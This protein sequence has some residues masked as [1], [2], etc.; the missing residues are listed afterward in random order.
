ME[1]RNEIASTGELSD[2]GL[3]LRRNVGRSYRR[4]I[5]IE[6]DWSPRPS[7]RLQSNVNLSR[8]RI[9]SWTQFYDVYGDDGSYLTSRPLLHRNVAPLL[10]PEVIVSQSLDY[11]FARM[12]TV[13]AIVRHV[14][15]SFLDNTNNER[16]VAPSFTTADLS[17]SLDLSRWMRTGS[18]QLHLQVNNAFDND[19]VFPSGYSYQFFAGEER[20]GISYY[21]PQATRHV[22]LRLGFRL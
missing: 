1:F 20:T 4:G 16:F 12:A 9:D 5:E 2:I 11:S 15:E 8:N 6:A 7:L 14:G 3:F 22:V 13:G 17:A 18:P 21:Y 19:R 10:T